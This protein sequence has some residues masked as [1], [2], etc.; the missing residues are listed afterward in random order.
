MDQFNSRPTQV[1]LAVE[2]KKS[3]WALIFGMFLVILMLAG[4]IF[5]YLKYFK[6]E[7]ISFKINKTADMPKIQVNAEHLES[8]EKGWQGM[9]EILSAISSQN[10][11]SFNNRLTVPTSTCSTLSDAC[12]SFMNST[13]AI[14]GSIKK[15][16]IQDA[17]E[18]KNQL[19]MLVP[20]ADGFTYVYFTKKSTGSL[21]WLTIK[22]Y[23]GSKEQL[24]DTD[25]DGLTDQEEL[26]VGQSATC[27]KTDINKK[28]SDGNGFWDSSDRFYNQLTYKYDKEIEIV[29]AI[30]EEMRQGF[31][32]GN[33]AL[34]YKHVT[35]DTL[36]LIKRGSV[37]KITDLTIKKMAKKDA[38]I[39]A[40]VDLIISNKVDNQNWIFIKQGTEW[41]YDIFTSYEDDIKKF[42]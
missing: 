10:G 41:K 14:L 6:K 13:K 16:S 25:Q 18:D 40:N 2:P 8:I 42:R 11:A 4:G 32:T 34:I 21:S 15:D 5:W 3:H 28:D 20:K 9:Q 33:N 27:I 23:Q 38:N 22:N 39:L 30:L 17:W 12:K 1:K 35:A 19:V 26:C 24:V 29:K 7:P 37:N 36:E 31:N